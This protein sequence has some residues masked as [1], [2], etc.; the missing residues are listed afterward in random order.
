[1]DNTNPAGTILYKYI[2]YV[3]N[4]KNIE[5]PIYVI[6]NKKGLNNQGRVVKEYD[7]Y[8]NSL[9]D[10]NN[11][12]TALNAKQIITYGDIEHLISKGRSKDRERW[13]KLINNITA[14]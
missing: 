4:D 13:S 11:I 1:L 7:S 3:T 2:G 5:K 10:F 14:V 12:D 6:V 8:S 9:F